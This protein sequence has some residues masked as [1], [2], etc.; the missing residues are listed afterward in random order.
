MYNACIAFAHV[1]H[2]LIAHLNLDLSFQIDLVVARHR[3]NPA[4][5]PPHVRLTQMVQIAFAQP[6]FLRKPKPKTLRFSRNKK[7]L[8]HPPL[9]SLA[10]R[11]KGLGGLQY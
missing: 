10:C 2:L 6:E 1:E 4:E 9:P 7:S 5:L 11:L 8:L 3:Q